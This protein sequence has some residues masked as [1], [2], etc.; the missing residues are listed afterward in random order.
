MADYN[1]IRVALAWNRRLRSY[2]Y[3]ERKLSWGK[4]AGVSIKDLPQDYLDW[5]VKNCSIPDWRSWL[6]REQAS[7]L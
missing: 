4:Y 3:K 6:E 1:K 7:R 2:E 5:A